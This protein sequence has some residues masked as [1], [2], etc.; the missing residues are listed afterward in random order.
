MELTVTIGCIASRFRKAVDCPSRIVEPCERHDLQ[1]SGL[2][3]ESESSARLEEVVPGLAVTEV[4][5]GA[6]VVVAEVVDVAAVVAWYRGATASWSLRCFPAHSRPGR[7]RRRAS[8]K[9]G[10]TAK[11]IGGIV[12]GQGDCGV[13]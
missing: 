13:P 7:S 9:A 2:D 1:P 10:V 3:V 12:S 8:V 4:L 11:D 6:E 5:V